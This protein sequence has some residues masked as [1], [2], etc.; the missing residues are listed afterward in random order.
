MTRILLTTVHRD[1]GLYDYF[2]ENSPPAFRWR[3]QMPRQISF[4]LRFL[5][6]NIPEIEILEYPTR[7]EYRNAL[8]KGWDVVGFSFYLEESNHVL[9][10]AEEARK[11][12][13]KGLGAG[14]Y[15]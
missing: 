9:G 1:L 12:G 15:R 7:A 3:F 2:R 11:A 8:K 6:Q 5:R 14:N 4:G 13:V 10:M